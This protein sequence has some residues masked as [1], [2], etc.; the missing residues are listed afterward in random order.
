MKIK[1]AP[2]LAANFDRVKGKPLRLVSTETMI[3]D[4]SSGDWQIVHIH[5]SSRPKKAE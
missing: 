3:L 2:A 4:K 5:W 1:T